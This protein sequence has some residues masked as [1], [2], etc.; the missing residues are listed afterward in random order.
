VK[1]GEWPGFQGLRILMLWV[2]LVFVV[3]AWRHYWR[4]SQA[5]A[6]EAPLAHFRFTAPLLIAFG[7]PLLFAIGYSLVRRR[8]GRSR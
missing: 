8:S 4:I 1:L 7:P 6:D 5:V 3:F 2:I